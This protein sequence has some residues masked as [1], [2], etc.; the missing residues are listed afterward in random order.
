M[1]S[2]V[3]ALSEPYNRVKKMELTSLYNIYSHDALEFAFLRGIL[4]S[5][6]C[7][8]IILYACFLIY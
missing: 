2:K 8:V 1:Y 5:K 3:L 6:M 4:S 7:L